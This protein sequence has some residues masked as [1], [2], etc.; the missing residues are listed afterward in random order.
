MDDFP[1]P[2]EL[3]HVIHIG[4]VTETENVVVGDSGLLLSRKVFRQICHGIAL[5]L[6]GSGVP[7]ETGGGCGV[8]PCGMIDKIGS[9]STVLNL[10]IGKIS[11]QLVYNG[12]DHFQMPQLFCT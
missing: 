11:C 10:R 1:F 3:D 12:A 5:D 9:E 6:H 7:G 8:N 2:Q 4:I